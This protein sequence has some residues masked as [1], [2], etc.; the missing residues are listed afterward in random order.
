MDILHNMKILIYG[1]SAIGKTTLINVLKPLIDAEFYE[2]IKESIIFDDDLHPLHS[3]NESRWDFD[4]VIW[5]YRSEKELTFNKK[6]Q[7]E[8]MGCKQIIKLKVKDK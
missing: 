5:L 1:I 7:L 6:S 4:L 2:N 3:H 8:G